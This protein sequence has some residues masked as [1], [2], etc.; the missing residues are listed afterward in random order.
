MAM[1]YHESY[2]HLLVCIFSPIPVFLD[3]L[4]VPFPSVLL[5][6]YSGILLYSLFYPFM[7]QI[8]LPGLGDTSPS[9]HAPIRV[10]EFPPLTLSLAFSHF[11]IYLF[12][13][14]RS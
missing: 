6:C 12:M 5:D 3:G 10:Q 11:D 2:P 14:A 7:G 1:F 8:K 4:P 9:R 13:C